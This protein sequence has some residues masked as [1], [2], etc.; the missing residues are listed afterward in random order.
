[1]ATTSSR[2]TIEVFSAGCSTCQEGIRAVQELVGKEHEVKVHDMHGD[3][4]AQQRAKELGIS[5]VPA[6]VV[7]G[8]L[9]QCCQSKPVDVDVVRSLL[10]TVEV[11]SAGCSTCQ[12]GIRAVREL[13]G[14]DYAVKVHDM[15]TDRA[16]Q[17]RAKE[18]GI[19]RLPAVVVRGK[20][21]RCCQSGEVDLGVIRSLIGGAKAS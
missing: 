16:A 2:Q 3:R 9:A 15:R 11:F 19:S 10:Y 8:R 21:A 5:R 12:E 6:V 13:A 17:A 4:G 1:M 20:L 18:L 14:D 7:N